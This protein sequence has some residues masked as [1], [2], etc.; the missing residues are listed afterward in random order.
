M[1]RVELLLV[2]TGKVV[3]RVG[4]GER[5]KCFSVGYV[6][7]EMFVNFLSGNVR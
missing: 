5:I 6:E 2:E 4:L 3:G 1:R 7:F